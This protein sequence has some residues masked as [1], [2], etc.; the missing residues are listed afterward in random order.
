MIAK[1]RQAARL[2]PSMATFVQKR[3]GRLEPSIP[4][5]RS[6]THGTYR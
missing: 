5:A 6:R 2:T 3:T 4:L 1:A